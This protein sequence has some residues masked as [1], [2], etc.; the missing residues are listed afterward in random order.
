MNID[1][2]NKAVFKNIRDIIFDV[3]KRGGIGVKILGGY[4]PFSVDANLLH[5]SAEGK[6]LEDP[7]V[8]PEEFIYSRTVSPFEAHI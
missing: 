8:E 5:I 7:W 2:S 6:I 3:K 4:F 1:D